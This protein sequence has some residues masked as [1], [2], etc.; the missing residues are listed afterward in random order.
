MQRE[1]PGQD[2]RRHYQKDA[3]PDKWSKFTE[4]KDRIP[5]SVA[6]AELKYMQM[7]R[8]DASKH[9][10]DEGEGYLEWGEG[11]RNPDGFMYT[12]FFKDQMGYLK[13]Q[14]GHS[15][16]EDG[17]VATQHAAMIGRCFYSDSIEEIKDNLRREDSKFAQECLKAMERNSE[18]S[19]KVA[20]KM[21]RKAKNMDYTS[22]M[23]MEV[24]VAM[25]M[26]RQEN[27]DL[28]V[29][30]VLMKPK[31]KGEKFHRNPGF[32]KD[33]KDR[34]IDRFFEPTP[35][36]KR[37]SVGSV[38]YALLPTRHTYERFSDHLRLWINE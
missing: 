7:L 14:L 26:V 21:L 1:L 31:A 20:L 17:V 11:G 23:E 10:N 32:E 37:V 8:E 34:E 27:F 9:K 19:M 2:L 33:I 12:N 15:T 24:D 3:F 5:S 29:S 22:A 13:S 38:K 30:Q 18:L 28:G 36:S 25:N 16:E 35:E 4:A 6:E